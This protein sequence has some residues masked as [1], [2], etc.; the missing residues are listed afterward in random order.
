VV[1]EEGTWG[2]CCRGPF[3]CLHS[4]L[5]T[6]ETQRASRNER[7]R[8]QRT[9]GVNCFSGNRICENQQLDSSLLRQKTN[10]GARSHTTPVITLKYSHKTSN[11]LCAFRCNPK[12]CSGRWSDLLQD[13]RVKLGYQDSRVKLVFVL[14]FVG[15]DLKPTLHSSR[16]FLAMAFGTCSAF[17]VPTIAHLEQLTQ[18]PSAH[19]FGPVLSN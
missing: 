8:E 5:E 1:S 11:C 19:G 4:A 16:A 18:P 12:H 14:S 9:I 3:P 17:R 6:L 13:S 10:P 2:K 15:E 7:I